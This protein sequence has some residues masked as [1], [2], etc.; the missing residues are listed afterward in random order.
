MD[1]FCFG[2][3]DLIV[4]KET[5]HDRIVKLGIYSDVKS[6]NTGEKKITLH[7]KGLAGSVWNLL[8][9][10]TCVRGLSIFIDPQFAQECFCEVPFD[11]LWPFINMYT[12]ISLAINVF[13]IVV[14]C[15]SQEPRQLSREGHI[16]ERG[17]ESKACSHLDNTPLMLPCAHK[18]FCFQPLLSNVRVFC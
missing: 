13:C 8:V 1:K 6:K 9:G 10:N 2:R 15:V 5:K 17:A 12:C 3:G 16:K 14:G 4:L 11:R 18:S 7:L